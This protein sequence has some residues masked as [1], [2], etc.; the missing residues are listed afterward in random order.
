MVKHGL[1]LMH[2]VGKRTPGQGTIVETHGCGTSASDDCQSRN[3][4]PSKTYTCT[5]Y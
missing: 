5:I 2:L 3:S 1:E 4:S